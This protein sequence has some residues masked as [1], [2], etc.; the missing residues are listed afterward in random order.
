MAKEK[1][2]D[3]SLSSM[4][5]ALVATIT[6]MTLAAPAFGQV[7]ASQAP[8]PAQQQTTEICPLQLD[9]DLSK[10]ALKKSLADAPEGATLAMTTSRYTCDKA[11]V[12]SISVSKV[13][14]RPREVLFV[15]SAHLATDWVRQDVN[16]TIQ[17]L[18]NGEVKQSEQWRSLTIGTDK[19]A[20]AYIP[21]GG[22]SPKVREGKW[23]LKRADFD[24]W[25]AEGS[26]PS[27]RVVLEVVP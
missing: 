1:A 19:G 18:V 15:A 14:Q 21:L 16:L 12:Q 3:G 17:L 23:W 10:E 6:Y 8:T 25:F 5:R 13:K 22:S 11:R 27:V 2:V 9:F 26:K 7:T 4:M 20:A 24:S